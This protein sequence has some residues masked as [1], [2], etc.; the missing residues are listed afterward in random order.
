VKIKGSTI[1]IPL[2]GTSFLLAKIMVL[3]FWSLGTIIV[4]SCEFLCLCASEGVIFSI[5]SFLATILFVLLCYL[6]WKSTDTPGD[7]PTPPSPPFVISIQTTTNNFGNVQ[8]YTLQ[9][10]RLF[11][12]QPYLSRV[13]QQIQTRRGAGETSPTQVPGQTNN[14]GTGA[15]GPANSS[16]SSFVFHRFWFRP[17]QGALGSTRSFRT[18]LRSRFHSPVLFYRLFPRHQTSIHQTPIVSSATTTTTTRANGREVGTNT[19]E[20]PRRSNQ[21]QNSTTT[22]AG[23][24]LHNDPPV[25]NSWEAE[26]GAGPLL[27]PRSDTTSQVSSVHS[28]AQLN[29]GLDS[30]FREERSDIPTEETSTSAISGDQK[31]ETEM[32]SPA[33]EGPLMKFTIKFLN[34][35]QLEVVT[36]ENEKIGNFKR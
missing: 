4:N 2:L 23:T 14:N 34:D 11:S 22:N 15:P 17:R 35:T 20:L 3:N 25:A 30:E 7:V 26:F 24:A 9:D 33:P 21:G 12:P 29:Q 8:R 5:P 36:S 1:D 27:S 16:P 18:F 31:E 28:P 32:D 13:F 10:I 6:S 19:T